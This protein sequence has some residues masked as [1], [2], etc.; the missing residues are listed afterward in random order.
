V[1]ALYTNSSENAELFETEEAIEI[2][3]FGTGEAREEIFE[4]RKSVQF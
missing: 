3:L 4:R 1:K 2:G